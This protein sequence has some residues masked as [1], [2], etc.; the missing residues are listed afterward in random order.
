MSDSDDDDSDTIPIDDP[1]PSSEDDTG[2]QLNLIWED[3]KIEKYNDH[4]GLPRWRC[5]WCGSSFSQWNATKAL[6]HVNKATGPSIRAC[7]STKI[8][9]THKTEYKRLLNLYTKKQTSLEKLAD[10]KKRKSD[11]YMDTAAELYASNK[12]K[13]TPPS[14][15][16]TSLSSAL[17]RPPTQIQTQLNFVTEQTNDLHPLDTHRSHQPKVTDS[18]ELQAESRLTMAIADLIHSCGLPFS[19]ASHHKFQRVLTYAKQAPR[20]YSPPNR[21]LVAG[22]L[23]DLNY[24]IYQTQTR[25]MLLKEADIYGITFFGDGA[26]IKKSP[27]INILASSI[28]EPAGC[29]SIVDCT[30]HLAADGTKDAS[31]IAS[32]FIPHIKSMEEKVPKCTDL[33]IFDGA[34]NVQ[35]AGSLLEAQFPHVSVI[36]GAEHV[37]SLFYSSVF[38]IKEFDCFKRLNSSL[39]RYFGSGSN[40]S[41]YATFSKHSRDHNQGRSIGLIRAS[42]T[43]MGGHVISMM[44]TLR[45]KDPLVNT[46]SSA[47][48]IQHNNKVSDHTYSV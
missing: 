20:N 33:I 27:L 45:L 36:H 43:R 17:N 30:G 13:K 24:E 23:L 29:L 19:I 28:H 47:S 22:K 12:R 14:A 40:H 9:D 16:S 4:K 10:S 34:S 1:P 7:T 32:L 18:I 11:Q 31:Y 15:T 42:D 8:D 25:E 26:T 6:F 48:F 46:L 35:K 2:K 21:N 5:L 3:D 44:R 41:F 39:Y 38:R 37:V